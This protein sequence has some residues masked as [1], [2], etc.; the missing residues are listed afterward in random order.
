M[1]F[2]QG[3]VAFMHSNLMEWNAAVNE[4][5]DIVVIMRKSRPLQEQYE[6]FVTMIWLIMAGVPFV[7][8]RA[9][10]IVTNEGRTEEF[11]YVFDPDRSN[12]T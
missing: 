11:H 4:D 1:S 5:G 9:R 3:I 2:K 7:A 6:S 12:C 10:M 8:E